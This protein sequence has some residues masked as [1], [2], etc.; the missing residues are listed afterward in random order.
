MK[1][2]D[3]CS[4]CEATAQALASRAEIANNRL[5][6]PNKTEQQVQ[7]CFVG[8]WEDFILHDENV[9]L[10]LPS[11]LELSE[12]TLCPCSE[13]CVSLVCT[14]CVLRG[15]RACPRC[16]EASLKHFKRMSK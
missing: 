7:W 11:E 10:Y 1:E 8:R 14:V 9:T 16:S 5:S 2:G 6:D 3:C 13:C 12:G 15:F 4:I